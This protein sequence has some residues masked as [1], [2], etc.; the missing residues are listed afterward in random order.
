MVNP[1]LN[2][3][4]N[5]DQFETVPFVNGMTQHQLKVMIKRMWLNLHN[6][7]NIMDSRR[8]DVPTV[9]DKILDGT[10]WNKKDIEDRYTH[11][12]YKGF[13]IRYDTKEK[14]FIFLNQNGET[15]SE[16]IKGMSLTEIKT[17]KKQQ[18]KTTTTPTE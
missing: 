14:I 3:P 8:N 13:L 12:F 2:I 11:G 18:T 9:I 15:V 4:E 1:K 6:L 10:K 16:P 5:K 17:I 7:A